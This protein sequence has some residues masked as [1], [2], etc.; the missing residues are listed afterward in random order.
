MSYQVAKAVVIEIDPPQIYGK[1]LKP[2]KL[3]EYHSE[4]SIHPLWRAA[5]LDILKMDG[6]KFE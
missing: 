6:K 4:H 2:A 3:H 1:G 5:V